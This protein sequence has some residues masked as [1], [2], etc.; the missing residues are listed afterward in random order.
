MNCR[1]ACLPAGWLDA[2][3]RAVYG[4]VGATIFTS[5]TFSFGAFADEVEDVE[6]VDD[7]D[8]VDVVD[9]VDEPDVLSSTVPVT[10]TLCPTWG[11]SFA[12]LASSR[13]SVGVMPAWPAV[14]AVL[15]VLLLPLPMLALVR[16]KFV[17]ALL[18][19]EVAPVVEV[20]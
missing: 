15:L 14:P 17:S 11:D 10:S 16:M 8:D 9:D 20:V 19:D 18:D 7:V 3:V 12:S 2:I 4:Q 6:E 13:N 5:S 1:P